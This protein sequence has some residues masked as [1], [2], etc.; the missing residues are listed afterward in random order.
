MTSNQPLDVVVV[1]TG[2]SGIRLLRRLRDLGFRA[3]ACERGSG[4]GGTWFWNRYPGARCDVESLEYQYSDKELAQEWSWSE[5]YAT[6]PEILSYLEHAA[7]R[8][9]VLPDIDFNTAVVSATWDAPA[10]VWRIRTS[11]GTEMET[12]FLVM[13]TGCLSCPNEPHFEG[14]DAFQGNVYHTGKW[15]EEGVD[16]TGQRVAVIGTGSSGIQSSPLIAQQASELFVVQ[17]T[18][19]FSVPAWNAPIDPDFRKMMMDNWDEMRAATRE[20]LFG[21]FLPRLSK[22]VRSNAVSTSPDERRRIFEEHWQRGGLGFLTAFG[23]LATDPESNRHASDFV[24]EKIQSAVKDP[25]TARLLTPSTGLACKRPCVDTG[26]FDMFNRANVHLVDIKGQSMEFGS[27]GITVGSRHLDVDAIVLATGFDAMTGAVLGVD[28]RGSGGLEL[29]EQWAGG[30]VNYLG[31]QVAGFPNMFTCTGPGS[32]SVLSNMVTSIEQHTDWIVDCLDAMRNT[33]A[34]VIEAREMSQS[35]WVSHANSLAE[36]T[37]W[38]WGCDNSWYKGAN[39]PGKP[40]VFMPYVGGC[41][42]YRAICD[43]EAAS[44]YTG[45]ILRDAQGQVLAPSVLQSLLATPRKV[46]YRTINYAKIFRMLFSAGGNSIVGGANPDSL[47]R[48]KL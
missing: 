25:E 46:A 39:I 36:P 11:Q 16:F 47:F 29:R 23:D 37:V 45:F 2:F 9:N 6:Q 34:T 3:R 31:V 40:H 44:G 15:P 35:H 33:G 43:A 41:G 1:G 26:Y 30:P 20:S 8:W 17:R 13:A 38:H 7:K 5:K 32:P 24:R 4:A 48:S 12:R 21:G 10:Q 19:N 42:Q 18:A 28:I 27:K 22:S 14:L